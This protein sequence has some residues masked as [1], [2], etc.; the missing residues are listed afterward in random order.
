MPAAPA[1]CPLA[2][3]NARLAVSIVNYRTAGMVIAALPA[4]LAELEG[5]ARAVV[6]I[7]DNASPGDDADRLEAHV[8][9]EGLAER[10]RV[11]RSARN[12][13]FAA[14]N[15]LAFAACRELGWTPDAVLL[16]NPDAEVRPGALRELLAVMASSP[17]I[18]VVGAS[19]ERR[20]GS[21]WTAAFHFPSIM[22]EFARGTGIGP[23]ARLWPVLIE[24]P[25]GPI[26]ADWVTGAA[27]LVRSEMLDEIGG[28]DESYFLYFEE[29]DFMLKAARA[30][31]ETWHAPAAR[32]LHVPGGA[33]GMLD[34]RPREGPMPAYWFDSW[35]RY[36]SKNHG[37]IRAR[38]AAAAKLAGLLVGE[39]HRLLRRRD[40]SLPPGF[41]TTFARRCLLGLGAGQDARP[42]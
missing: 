9:A 17:R 13:G 36:F 12:G 4:L 31:W 25:T 42:G 16:L 24:E 41:V 39:A 35:R 14:G 30:G 3:E 37:P 10:V 26:R 22:G 38:A 7:V 28:M 34:G 8:A 23:I 2:P 18:G 27:M 5:L 32:V 1:P 19:L 11:I 6:L 15:N 21:G 40:R 29:V 33:T 20:P